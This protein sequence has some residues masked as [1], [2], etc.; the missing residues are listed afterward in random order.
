VQ[1][2]MSTL[3]PQGAQLMIYAAMAIVIL[4]RPAG[5]MGRA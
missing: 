3:W 5:L 2:I 4:T 1:S